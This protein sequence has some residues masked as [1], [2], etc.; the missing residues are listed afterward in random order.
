MVEE[1]RTP[2]HGIM[3][4]ADC[5]LQRLPQTFTSE[6]KSLLTIADSGRHLIEL[7]NKILDFE[8]LNSSEF[9]LENTPF[10]VLCEAERVYTLTTF[11]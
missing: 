11:P 5:L 2:L 3:A 8:K 1:L 4:M 9:A 10:S 6:R 7:L